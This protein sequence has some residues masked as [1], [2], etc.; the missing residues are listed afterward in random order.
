MERGLGGGNQRKSFKHRG[1]GNQINAV[2]ESGI[3]SSCNN[4]TFTPQ[5]IILKGKL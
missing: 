5:R 1:C 2:T 3:F 4:F